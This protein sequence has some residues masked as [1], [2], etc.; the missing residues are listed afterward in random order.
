L[1]LAF[2]TLACPQWSTEQIVTNACNSGYDAIELR[3]LDGEV[4][5]PVKDAAKVV[6]AVKLSRSK[7]LE[8][9]ALDTSSRVNQPD[10]EGRAATLAE[11]QAWFR[12]A[13]EV[14]VPLLRIFGGSGKNDKNDSTP[15][16][17]EQE[18]DRQVIDFLGQIAQEAERAHVIV[19]LETHDFFSSARRVGSILKA[20][21]SPAVGALWDSQHPYRVGETA[22]EVYRYL[23]GDKIVHVHVKDALRTGPTE[24][25]WQLKLLGEGE[26]PVR[27]QLQLLQQ[28]GFNGYASV[29]WEKKWHPEIPEPEV[30]LPQHIRWLKALPFLQS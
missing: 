12:L 17:T 15:Q 7:G 8:V 23:G 4:I 22:E 19:A 25:G 20:V 2:S 11:L 3:L 16:P 5:D 1:K 6:Q 28:N 29:E 21:N 26:V 30:A 27:E 24:K 18:V 10:K 14:Q 9:C 13:Q